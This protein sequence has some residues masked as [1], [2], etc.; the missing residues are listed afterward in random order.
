MHTVADLDIYEKLARRLDA[1]PNGFPSTGNGEELRLLAKLFSHQDAELAG[2]LNPDLEPLDGIAERTGYDRQQLRK[3][4]KDMARRGLIATGRTEQGLGF[5]LLPFVVGIYEYQV[6]TIDKE[7][8]ALVEDYF[9]K[10]FCEALR[11]KP[12]FHRILPVRESISNTMEIRPYESATEIIDKAQAWGVLDCIC[13]KQKALIG[14]PCEHPLDVCMV[15]SAR[16]GAFDGSDTIKALNR[17]E[18]HSTLKRAADAGL[19]HSVSNNQEGIDYICNCCTCSCGI[20]RGMANLGMA[21]IVA[22]SSFISSVDQARCSACG[23]CLDYCQFGAL[24]LEDAIRVD[25]IRCVGCG[26]CVPACP[27]EALAMILRSENELQD[28]PATPEDWKQQRN[29]FRKLNA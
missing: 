6:D 7:L 21:G 23:T 12:Q 13:R 22:H 24:L 26:L 16:P 18:A 10:A 19:V 4:L 3:Q 14:E 20:L 17:E 29:A 1:L 28:I 2:Q 8:A 25:S 15:L 9:Q 5:G 11:I 27:E